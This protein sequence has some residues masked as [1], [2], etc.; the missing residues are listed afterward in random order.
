M[1]LKQL[2]RHFLSAYH[3]KGTAQTG[4]RNT[5]QAFLWKGP[6]YWSW[7]L[8]MRGKCQVSYTYRDYRGDHGKCRLGKTIFAYF[9]SFTTAH[10]HL[11]VRSSYM[12]LGPQFLQLLPMDTSRSPEH[13]ASRVNNYSPIRLYI[14]SYF[15][16]CCLRAWHPFSLNL[17]ADWGP[18]LWN[19]DRSWHI[20]NNWHLSRINQT[21]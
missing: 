8:N 3:P 15:K 18:S 9:L 5:S 1:G 14:F 2:E 13:N 4:Y 17:D 11:P 21:A 6:I 16:G 20:L 12:C 19:T 10:W 7:S